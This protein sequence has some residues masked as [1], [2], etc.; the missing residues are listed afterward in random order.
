MDNPE[1]PYSFA[2][3]Y[4]F[5]Q[6]SDGAVTASHSVVLPATSTT[7]TAN[8]TPQFYVIDYVNETC[9]GSINVSPSSPTFDGFYPSGTAL[10]FTETPNAGWLFTGW[11]YDFSG[12]S[13]LKNAHHHRRSSRHRRLQYRRDAAQSHQSEPSL[14]GFRKPWFYADLERHG[15]HAELPRLRERNIPRG[16]FH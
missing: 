9:A 10:T 7:Y 2:T 14:G 3:R 16:N 8:L 6:W 5:N 15:L 11:Q 4:A 12:T 13:N 1:Y